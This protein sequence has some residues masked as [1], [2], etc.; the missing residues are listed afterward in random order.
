MTTLQVLMAVDFETKEGSLSQAHGEDLPPK[1][2]ADPP[3]L[4]HPPPKPKKKKPLTLAWLA[5]GRG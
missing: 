3:L 1:E 5:Q 2:S 4:A